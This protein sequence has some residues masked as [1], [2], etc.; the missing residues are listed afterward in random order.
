MTSV[1]TDTQLVV[2]TLRGD[3]SAASQ[4]FRRYLEGIYNYVFFRV[5]RNHHDT[6]ELT[7][8]VFTSAWKNLGQFDASRSFWLW[9]CGI[10]RRSLSKYYRKKK[11]RNRAETMFHRME[12]SIRSL[13]E[14][15][16]SDLPLPD[17]VMEKVEI[18]EA[19]NVALTAMN[20]KYRALLGLKYFKHRSIKNIAQEWGLSVA[21]VNSALQ[22][23]REGLRE[24]LGSMGK[25]WVAYG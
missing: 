14:K 25:E 16:E 23:A 22:R 15:M 24:M 21:A 19:I 12:D 1:E 8:E 5:D 20:P 11:V 13:L 2:R 9:L 3:V 4:L 6:E 10:A 18:R 7:Q 17:A